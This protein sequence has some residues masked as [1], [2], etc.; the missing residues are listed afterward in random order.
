MKIEITNE[1]LLE[2]IKPITRA[3][4]EDYANTIKAA[5]YAYAA[6]VAYLYATGLYLRDVAKAPGQYLKAYGEV[7]LRPQ[8]KL[9]AA[10]VKPTPVKPVPVK[11]TP[12]KRTRS[13]K[14]SAVGAKNTT[15]AATQVVA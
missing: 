5:V 3:S 15:P 13:R 6:L 2:T 11:P 14:R 8:L 9:V 10:P 4:V 7:A 12:V 1:Q